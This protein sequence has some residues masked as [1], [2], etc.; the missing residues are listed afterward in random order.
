MIKYFEQEIMVILKDGGKN[1]QYQFNN[2][3]ELLAFD[4][5][6]E[7]SYR[8]EVQIVKI[9][10]DLVYSSLMGNSVDLQSMRCFF[11]G[12]NDSGFRF[13]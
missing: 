2:A 6:D 5:D 8:A 12:E 13:C 10:N 3:T 11:S 7:H 1:Y 9:G 4:W